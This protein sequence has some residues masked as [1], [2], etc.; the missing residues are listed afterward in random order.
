MIAFT[1]LSDDQGGGSGSGSGSGSCK[2]EMNGSGSGSSKKILE[3]ETASFKKLEAEAL[4]AEAI[5]NSPLPHHWL[6]AHLVS[7]EIRTNAYAYPNLHID[8]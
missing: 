8:L 6:N 5:K 3:A 4:H 1:V 2:R 7:L